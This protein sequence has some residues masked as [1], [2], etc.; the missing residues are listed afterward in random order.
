MD[1]FFVDL[2]AS[3]SVMVGV[4]TP[5]YDCACDNLCEFCVLA[6]SGAEDGAVVKQDFQLAHVVRAARTAAVELGHDGVHTARI[7]TQHAT[8]RAVTVRGRVRPKDQ[9]VRFHLLL[10]LI[11]HQ[12]RLDAH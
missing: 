11:Q 1:K 7:V 10:Q 6:F 5:G 8:D 2:S 9:A 4:N 12:S 3:L